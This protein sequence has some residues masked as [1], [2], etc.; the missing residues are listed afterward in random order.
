MK[1]SFKF[2]LAALT[3]TAALVAC[4]KE[5]T[6]PSFENDKVNPAFEGSRVIAVSFGSQTKTT[7]EGFQPKFVDEK[8][9]VLIS[10]GKAVDTCKVKVE[11][12]VATITTNLTGP[13]TAVYPYTAAGM[14]GSN[15]KQIETVL[16]SSVQSGIFADA[17]ICMAENI[18]DK[19]VFENK[20]ALFCIT[21]GAG[22]T[23]RYVE[24]I[25]AGPEIANT[26]SG[27][28]TKKN[29][30]HV[31]TESADSVWVSILVPDGLKV[32]DLS[33]ADGSKKKTVNTGDDATKAISV[34]ALFTVSNTGWSEPYVE[35]GELKWAPQ[36]LAITDSGKKVWKGDNPTAVK[37]PGTDEDVINGDYF[38]WAA[39][40]KGYN[41]KE[42]QK[43]DSL[44][45]YT[46]FTNR[47]CGDTG[48][49]FKFIG[50]KQFNQANAP[51][52]GIAYSK[53]NGEDKDAKSK[54]DVSDDV[55]NI[56]LGG[57]W[58]MPT[59]AEFQAM[60]DVTYWKWNAT[61]Q[62]YY[63]FTPNPET[64]AGKVN[65]GTGTYN[66]SDALL[67]F[68]A[69]GYGTFTGLDEGV[70]SQGF[71]WSSII[72]SFDPRYPYYLFFD[73]LGIIPQYVDYPRDFGFPVRPVSD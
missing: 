67:F 20:T 66:K 62:G 45:I 29:K 44:L 28:Y 25:T 3:A 63:V 7:L 27:K 5:T 32:R 11:G 12:D 73:D 4:T 58:R 9:T 22:D 2:I 26:T 23:T 35:I 15:P 40:Y 53:Y 50:S 8:D 24:V 68:P 21:P 14:N 48:N 49:G 38:Q 33:F 57:N 59:S 10:N 52:G 18:T 70:P 64:D 60:K 6:P 30:I 36:N 16:V 72:N 61:D 69:A 31:A 1:A 37:V 41:V 43:P 19:A 39:S 34:N 13:L 65:N 56:I 42:N 71:Y 17:N 54:L 51:Y 46:E 47:G 55:A